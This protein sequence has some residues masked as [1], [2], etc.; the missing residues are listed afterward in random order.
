MAASSDN[1]ADYDGAVTSGGNYTGDANTTF[2]VEI[3]ADG[4]ADGT[5]KYRVSTDGGLSFD[6]NGGIGFDV[7]SNGP[8]AIADGV[9]INFEDDGTLRTGDR[10][11]IDTFNPHCEN[12]KTPF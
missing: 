8:L 10:F 1:A 6:D 5:A 3:M 11:S 4:A 9:T 7:T 12:R 2:I